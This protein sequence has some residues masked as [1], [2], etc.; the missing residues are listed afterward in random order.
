MSDDID[1]RFEM[2]CD[3]SV[4]DAKRI[5]ELEAALSEIASAARLY[6]QWASETGDYPH[7]EQGCAAHEALVSAVKKLDACKTEIEHRKGSIDPI[8]HLTR[9]T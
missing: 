3:Q 6:V 4:A 8:E 7:D 9:N 1:P 2:L 5:A